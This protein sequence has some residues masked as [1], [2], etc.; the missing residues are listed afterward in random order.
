MVKTCVFSGYRP[1]KLPWGYREKDPRCVIFKN[2]LRTCLDYLIGQG[3]GNFISG[4]AL[5]FDTYAAEAVLK[6]KKQYPWLTLEMV[7]PFDGQAND[8]TD[9]DK[10]RRAHIFEQA[11][12]ITHT[13]H[14][15]DPKVYYRR[16]LYMVQKADYLLAAFDGKPGGTQMTINLAHAHG[17]KTGLF[18]IVK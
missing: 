14:V 10:V 7:V 15:Y 5:G 16:N 6:L 17:V 3:Y 4:S 11:D 8:W 18:A 13:S 2:R 9:I 1:N 12:F